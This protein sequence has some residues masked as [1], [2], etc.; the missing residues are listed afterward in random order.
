[1]QTKLIPYPV[2]MALQPVV[3]DGM[4]VLQA[5][6]VEGID[7]VSP[8]LSILKF[9]IHFFAVG[10]FKQE[11]WHRDRRVGSSRQFLDFLILGR[12]SKYRNVIYMED[13]SLSLAFKPFELQALQITHE[14]STP[15]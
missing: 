7:E 15:S 9:G 6:P 11:V 5:A 1:M 12:T 8:R 2:Q 3:H 14:G 13:L 4:E 10:D